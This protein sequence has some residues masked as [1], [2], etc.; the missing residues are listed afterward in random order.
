[1]RLM[2]TGLGNYVMCQIAVDSIRC[3]NP[4]LS[5]KEIWESTPKIKHTNV[6]GLG[7]LSTRMDLVG[8]VHGPWWGSIWTWWVCAR[9]HSAC[10]CARA[11]TCTPMHAFASWTSSPLPLPVLLQESGLPL[12]ILPLPSELPRA[13]RACLNFYFNLV[14]LSAEWNF[15]SCTSSS[16][17]AAASLAFMSLDFQWEFFPFPLSF[18]MHVRVCS[19]NEIWFPHNYP[20]FS[21]PVLTC[22]ALTAK[23]CWFLGLI[24]L[25][26]W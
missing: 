5:L 6:Q 23:Y 7:C 4:R 16:S 3:L 15:A 10:A 2:H 22:F 9:V 1:M 21:L 18:Y 24:I 26:W 19:I 12:W 11:C 25:L 8:L 14:L 13:V 17:L 20:C